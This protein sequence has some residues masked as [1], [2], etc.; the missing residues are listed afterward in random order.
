VVSPHTIDIEIPKINNM[1]LRGLM[2][3]AKIMQ[4]LA[5]NMLFGKETHMTISNKPPCRDDYHFQG[6]VVGALLDMP[7]SYRLGLGT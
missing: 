3:F 6:V 2:V 4:N 7:L 1:V 5:N